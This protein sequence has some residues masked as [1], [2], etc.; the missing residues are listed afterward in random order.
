MKQLILSSLLA[1]MAVSCTQ[2]PRYTITGTVDNAELNGK[3][4]YLYAY[5]KADALPMD[6]ALSARVA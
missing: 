3:Q 6:S 4:I 5:G 2:T 1:A